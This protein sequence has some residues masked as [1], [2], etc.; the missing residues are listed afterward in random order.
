M[1]A[2]HRLITSGAYALRL[3]EAHEDAVHRVVQQ[4]QTGGAR[5]EQHP[6]ARQLNF[7]ALAITTAVAR[8]LEPA[9]ESV[10]L[11]KFVDTRAVEMP[12][13]LCELLCVIA[14]ATLGPEHEDVDNPA[15]IVKL[16]NRYAAAGCPDLLRR[17]TDPDLRLTPLEK[18][19]EFAAELRDSV[20]D[21]RETTAEG[22]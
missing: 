3:P 6:F 9:G 20:A 4:H 1:S 15:E 11:R 18:A 16:A 17:L 2:I 22:G 10:Q 13:K 14:L 21:E 7:W 5:P 19:L 8:G 12:E